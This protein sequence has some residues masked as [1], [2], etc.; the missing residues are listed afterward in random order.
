MAS[1]TQPGIGLTD[2]GPATNV[3]FHSLPEELLTLIV[4]QLCDKDNTY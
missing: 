4:E 1:T 2:N 3:G